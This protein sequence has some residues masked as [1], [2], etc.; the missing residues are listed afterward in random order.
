MEI[1][2][3]VDIYNLKTQSR[4]LNVKEMIQFFQGHKQRFWCWGATAWTVITS[5]DEHVALRFLVSGLLF[6][7]HVYVRCN[8][9]D[10][11][12]VYFTTTLSVF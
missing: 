10:E 3:K 12:D 6:R 4:T 11:M 9:L 2:S 7:G 1:G 8:G 5:H